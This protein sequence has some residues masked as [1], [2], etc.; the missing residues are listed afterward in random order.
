MSTVYGDS[1]G[2]NIVGHEGTVWGTVQWDS[3]RA[4]MGDIMRVQCRVS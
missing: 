1:M 3:I 2:D 4:D